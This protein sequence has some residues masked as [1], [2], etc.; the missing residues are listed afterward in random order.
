MRSDQEV[1]RN[2]WALARSS[3]TLV[4]V[5]A[6]TLICGTAGATPKALP[7]WTEPAT[8]MV[9][10]SLPKTCFQMGA[11][12][13]IDPPFDSHWKRIG[14]KGN[15]AEDEVPRHEVCVDAFWMAKTE[16]SEADWAKVMGGEVPAD[17]GRRAKVG[18]T[19]TQARQ[20]AQQLTSQSGGKMRFR[21]PTEAEW[22]YAC[23]AGAGK[24]KAEEASHLAG[25]AWFAEAPQRSYEVRETGMLK[26]NDFG[27]HDMLGNAWEWTEDS[28]RNDAYARHVLYNPKLEE[29]GAPRVI[30]GGSF[31]TEF[32]QTR[33][34]M[35]GRYDPAETLD[36]IGMRLVRER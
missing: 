15:L 6:F 11:E 9:F 7:T 19:W 20:F 25:K 4:A 33:C 8:G 17:G 13:P 18:V 12:K 28:Y 1:D 23:L 34:A 10:V 36:A 3:T 29:A 21:L 24:D 26:P 5:A 35:R 2:A 22:E 31:R 16:V 14:Y 30:R 27:L 32:A